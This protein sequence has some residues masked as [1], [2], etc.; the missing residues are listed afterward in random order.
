MGKESVPANG[1]IAVVTGGASGLG[2]AI[3]ES[4]SDDGYRVVILDRSETAQ[5]RAAELQGRGRAAAAC[6]GDLSDTASIPALA[7]RILGDEGRCDVLVNNAGT[8]FKTPDGKR[9]AF[10]AVELHQWNASL[11]LHMTAPMLLSQAF[12]PG[13]KE[14]GWGRIVNMGSRAGR[15]YIFTAA[16]FYAASKAGLVGL[17][18][19]IAGE[20][21]PYGI[22]CNAIAPGRIRTPLSEAFSEEMKKAALAELLVGRD[23]DPAEVGALVSFLA[24]EQAGYITGAVVDINGGGFMAP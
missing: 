9:I 8:Q 19:S 20:Y 10:D 23:G 24:S 14:R 1:K 5:E 2:W 13:M 11:A 3:C 7:A 12:L 18:R 15:T 4:L 6:V 16:A 22:T 21:G 17:T